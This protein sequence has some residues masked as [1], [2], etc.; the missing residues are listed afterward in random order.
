MRKLST[1]ALLITVMAP[2]PAIAYT[3]EDVQACTPDV[4]RLCLGAI[5]DAGRVTQCLVQHKQQ[6]SAACTT[7]FNRPRAANADRER[8]ATIQTTSY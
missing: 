5:P 2:L 7:V 1:I 8:P 3:Q 4:M 6:L